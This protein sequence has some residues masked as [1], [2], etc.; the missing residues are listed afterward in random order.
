[1]TAPY[2]DAVHERVAA[3]LAAC[4]EAFGGRVVLLRRATSTLNA[5]GELTRG[6]RFTRASLLC[7]RLSVAQFMRSESAMQAEDIQTGSAHHVCARMCALILSPA[8]PHPP[9]AACSNSA[10]LA[11]FDPDGS[12]AR[13]V[14][15]SLGIPVLRHGAATSPRLMPRPSSGVITL[16]S[17]A[18]CY[19]PRCIPSR[20][21]CHAGNAAPA[22]KVGSPSVR[23]RHAAC[24]TL[25]M[26]PAAALCTQLPRSLA[27]AP[28]SW[29][30]TSVAAQRSWRADPPL[31]RLAPAHAG[32][33][34][35]HQA[36]CDCVRC[37]VA[38]K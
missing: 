34:C 20:V 12:V 5:G 3:S 37:V 10:G 18:P 23:Q 13:E 25:L 17:M 36:E 35:T 31:A 6:L 38:Y 15:R 27:G 7:G 26:R 19:Q 11:Q 4:L 1:M 24:A 28:P 14:E 2:V 32:T 9:H 22:R 29:K 8:S 21:R 16:V 30:P 33:R